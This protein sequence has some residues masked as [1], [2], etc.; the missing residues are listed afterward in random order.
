MAFQLLEH[1]GQHFARDLLATFDRVRAV[2][3]D[4]GFDDRHDVLFLAQRGISRQRVRI[5][6]DREA[7]REACADVDH[8]APLGETRT[9][10]VVL[11][12]PL[13]QA[14]EPF[15]DRLVGERS[16]RLRAHVDLDAGH[17]TELGEEFRERHAVAGLLAQRLVVE[18]DAADRLRHRRR[19]EQQFAVGA[20]RLFGGL[21]ADLVETLLDRAR[22]LVRGQNALVCGDHC[23]RH[24]LQV[25]KTHAPTSRNVG[26][27][28]PK[29]GAPPL[30]A[31]N[32]GLN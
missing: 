32:I 27:S 6:F 31:T 25:Y 29:L 14:I 2:H 22:A 10:L 30:S 20:A 1:F 13:A 7:R 19:R 23:F 11:H 18:N 5:G 24:V 4:L 8:G 12:Q 17:D 15:G 16:Q 26:A 3:Q 21:E 9:E 28:I